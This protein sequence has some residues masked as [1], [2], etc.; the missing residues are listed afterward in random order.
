MGRVRSM[1]G[2][3]F[4]SHGN[5]QKKVWKGRRRVLMNHLMGRRYSI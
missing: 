3:E 2:K 5:E 1:G 4:Q